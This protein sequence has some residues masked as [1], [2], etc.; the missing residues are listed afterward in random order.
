MAETYRD[1]PFESICKEAET[2]IRKQPSIKLYQKFTCDGCGNR[3]TMDKPNVF[4]E[5]GTCDNCPTVTDIKAKG[6]NYLAHMVLGI[7][8]GEVQPFGSQAEAQEALKKAQ[9]EREKHDEE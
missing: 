8:Q 9:A 3:L 2:L 6:C 5:T 1:F 7:D 4:F